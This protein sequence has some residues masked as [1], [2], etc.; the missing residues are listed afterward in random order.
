MVCSVC[1]CHGDTTCGSDAVSTA[2]CFSQALAAWHRVGWVHCDIKPTN[3]GVDAA[4]ELFVF[5][6]GLAMQL[7]APEFYPVR[8][9]GPV[10]T[11]GFMAPE[12][13]DDEAGNPYGAPADVYS[14]CACVLELIKEV[15]WRACGWG[16]TASAAWLTLLSRHARH[17]RQTAGA[18]A[19]EVT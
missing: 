15:S 16:G 1:S 2:R 8:M 10:G 11:P 19:R 13:A 3:M 17:G 18:G 6:L 7:N 4:G 9:G 14:A 5:D 12:V